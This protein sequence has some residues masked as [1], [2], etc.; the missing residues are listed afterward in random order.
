M[1]KKSNSL[2]NKDY[3]YKVDT[4]ENNNNCT[5]KDLEKKNYLT[6]KQQKMI[7]NKG[8]HPNRKSCILRRPTLL[9]L[10]ILVFKVKGQLL[11]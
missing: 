3:I 2:K 6:D 9:V 7:H 4:K 11:Y 10:S 1:K 5:T 8:R